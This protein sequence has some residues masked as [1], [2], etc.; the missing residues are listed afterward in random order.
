MTQRSYNQY[1]PISHALDVVGDRWTLLIIRDLLLGPKRFSDLVAGLPGIG[2]NLLTERLK[3]LEQGGV[4]Q[5][6]TLPPPAPASLYEL[7]PYGRELEGPLMALAQWGG[8]TLGP[9]QPGQ[10]LSRDTLLLTA[11]AML[12]AWPGVAQAAAYR[13]HLAD[14]PEV[15]PLEFH[16]VADAVDVGPG[17]GKSTL[18]ELSLDVATLYALAGGH[19]THDSALAEGLLRV[20]EPPDEGGDTPAR[21]PTT[22]TPS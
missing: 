17:Q 13:V 1:C 15:S 4:I 11:R 21:A 9:Q 7:T 18:L 16:R 3:L 5:R 14:A 2:T 10:V 8:Q 19:L 20:D 22:S 12:R 6:R